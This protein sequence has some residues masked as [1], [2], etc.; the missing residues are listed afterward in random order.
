M[1]I[2]FKQLDTK[3][4]SKPVADYKFLGRPAYVLKGLSGY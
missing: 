3:E 4:E 1:D 2:S